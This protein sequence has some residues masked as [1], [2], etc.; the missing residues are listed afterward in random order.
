MQREPWTYSL[1][2]MRD[3]IR[4]A[5]REAGPELD[6]AFCEDV[7][8]YTNLVPGRVGYMVYIVAPPRLRD[9]VRGVAYRAIA[10]NEYANTCLLLNGEVT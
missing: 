4:V 10:E 2:E 1:V 9:L 8:R 7:I 5:L 3:A 6:K